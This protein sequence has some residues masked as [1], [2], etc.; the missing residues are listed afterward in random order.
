MQ[1]KLNIR[2]EAFEYRIKELLEPGVSALQPF[3][4]KSVNL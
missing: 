1:P 3:L 2:T 4:Q